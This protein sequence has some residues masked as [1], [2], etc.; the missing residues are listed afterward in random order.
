MLEGASFFLSNLANFRIKSS[1]KCDC[2]C[3]GGFYP[4]LL[5]KWGVSSI[6]SELVL[7]K[8][9]VIALT[10]RAG[11]R[12][13]LKPSVLQNATV[14]SW[15]ECENGQPLVLYKHFTVCSASHIGLVVLRHFM[16]G[17]RGSASATLCLLFIL[18][19]RQAPFCCCFL[20]MNCMKVLKLLM[21]Y[22]RQCNEYSPVFPPIALAT[23]VKWRTVCICELARRATY[24]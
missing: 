7:R 14:R 12:Y 22:E 9:V 11:G 5:V 19:Y 24:V 6:R 21:C 16:I 23:A 17:S 4:V 13:P 8:Q 1:R 10:G 18:N 20:R 3:I 15:V 2:P